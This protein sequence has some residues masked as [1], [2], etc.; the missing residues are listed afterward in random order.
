MEG[1]SAHGINVQSASDT[2]S[3][4]QQLIAEAQR[5]P[6]MPAWVDYRPLL[7]D[8]AQ[9]VEALE[10]CQADVAAAQQ[11]AGQHTAQNGEQLAASDIQADPEGWHRLNWLRWVAGKG[12]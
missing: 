1:L 12:R 5:L 11:A 3:T 2:R 4:V 7:A 9:W 6:E 8:I 10:G